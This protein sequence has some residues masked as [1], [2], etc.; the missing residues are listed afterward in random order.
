MIRMQVQLREPQVRRLRAL[1]ADRGIS[2][3]EAVRR[4]LD[5]ALAGTRGDRSA[6]YTR[7]ASL[8]GSLT[9]REGARDL[10][11]DHDRYLDEALS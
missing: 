9:D 7:A 5:E 4:C 6:L 11:S 8:V 1:A 3:S 10:S 2:F